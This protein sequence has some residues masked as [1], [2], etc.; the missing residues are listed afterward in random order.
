M[1]SVSACVLR[2]CCV[3]AVVFFR[4]QRR[5]H[6]AGLGR[7]P[8]DPSAQAHLATLKFL[9]LGKQLEPLHAVEA[10]DVRAARLGARHIAL[11]RSFRLSLSTGAHRRLLLRD[12]GGLL[13]QHERG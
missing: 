4:R 5:P 13:A 2:V 9:L 7:V 11:T 6:L 8:L 3:C 12:W 1:M 10:A